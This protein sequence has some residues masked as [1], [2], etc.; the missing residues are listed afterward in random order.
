[1]LLKK[2]TVWLLTML[3]LVIVLS[4]Y[5][6]TTPTEPQKEMA[7]TVQKEDKQ[8][9]SDQTSTEQGQTDVK[10][11]T[12]QLVP[13]GTD[14]TFEAMRLDLMDERNKYIEELTSMV[15]NTELSVEERDKASETIKQIRGMTEKEMVLETLLVSMDNFEAALVR[16]EDHNIKVTVK[17]PELSKSAA[18]DVVRL[19]SDEI[20]TAQNVTVELQPS[21]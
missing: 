11:T 18:N 7:T 6:V 4:V 14:D 3:S 5:Y 12:K 20:P 21:K 19:I 1:M 9:K 13:A 10:S 17:A 8:A 16:A 2:Q 15:A